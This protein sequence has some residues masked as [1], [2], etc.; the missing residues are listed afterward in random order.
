M[1]TPPAARLRRQLRATSTARAAGA[2]AVIEAA[3]RR[4][5]HRGAPLQCIR[6]RRVPG[7]GA[8]DTTGSTGA[9]MLTCTNVV[10][11][12]PIT[13]HTYDSKQRVGRN[14]CDVVLTDAETNARPASLV[15]H[16][17][18]RSCRPRSH[19]RVRS[20]PV[21]PYRIYYRREDDVEGR[22]GARTRRQSH[23]GTATPAG[24]RTCRPARRDETA[25][26]T[27]QSIGKR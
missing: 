18:P 9:A 24:F 12:I 11:F 17:V 21:R 7:H 25:R 16:P 10:S 27:Q 19:E 8:G 15:N 4:D 1:A 13:G 3:E 23:S 20:W 14:T 26:R 6:E 22:A 2:P 5:D